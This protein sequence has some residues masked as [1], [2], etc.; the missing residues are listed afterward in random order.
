VQTHRE[1]ATK[2]AVNHLTAQCPH[3]VVCHTLLA[4]TIRLV[5]VI[6][7]MF[8]F[9]FQTA[10]LV[11]RQPGRLD[12]IA[13]GHHTKGSL[14]RMATRLPSLTAAHPPV[15]AAR[16]VVRRILRPGTCRAEARYTGEGIAAFPSD[17]KSPLAA[18]EYL[19][20]LLG[21]LPWCVGS[22]SEHFIRVT[23]RPLECRIA[24]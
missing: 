17:M 16:P 15:A 4:N 8:F 14:G 23:L 5:L 3:L 20:Y 10:L 7:A 21:V 18:Q 2:T 1:N 12:D 24:C 13:C 11:F 6:L 22:A 19:Q 9:L